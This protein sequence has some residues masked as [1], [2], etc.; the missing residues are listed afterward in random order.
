MNSNA[1][2]HPKI[3]ATSKTL[4]SMQEL[5][6]QRR[7]FGSDSNS[8]RKMGD[9]QNSNPGYRS[10]IEGRMI[11]VNDYRSRINES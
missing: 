3:R 8:D 6:K 2:S 7:D 11:W 1:E 10:V 5:L 4:D 9:F